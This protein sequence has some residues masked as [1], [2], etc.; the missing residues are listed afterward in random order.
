MPE[1]VPSLNVHDDLST[2]LKKATREQRQAIIVEEMCK[3]RFPYINVPLVVE[4]STGPD[5]ADLTEIA[6]FR[7]D[8]L[9]KMENPYK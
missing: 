3:H 7:S 6:K 1:L 5:W 4:V 9:F 2:W 8:E